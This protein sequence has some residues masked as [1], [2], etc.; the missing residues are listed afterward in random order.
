[1]NCEWKDIEHNYIEKLKADIG[2]MVKTRVNMHP[3]ETAWLNMNLEEGS[4]VEISSITRE[5]T[6]KLFILHFKICSPSGTEKEGK[7][8]VSTR[9]LNAMQSDR[10]W[11]GEI[12]IMTFVWMLKIDA[13]E[14]IR[15]FEARWNEVNV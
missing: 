5:D 3:E 13:D 14:T 7:L 12:E 1:M 11:E 10:E 9:K 15:S 8:K 6:E 4:E 2:T